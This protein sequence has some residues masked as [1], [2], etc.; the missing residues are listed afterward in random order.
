MIEGRERKKARKDEK[1]KEKKRKEKKRKE[2]KRK[3]KKR[4]EK[5]RKG[6]KRKEKERKGKKRKE[7]ERKGKERK[8]KKRKKQTFRSS[9]HLAVRAFN[10][11]LS[12]TFSFLKELFH[13][14]LFFSLNITELEAGTVAIATAFDGDRLLR[15]VGTG[16]ATSEFNVPP[17]V[18]WNVGFMPGPSEAGADALATGFDNDD[19]LLRFVR[20]ESATNAFNIPPPVPGNVGFAP[21]SRRE[22]KVPVTGSGML[23][24]FV[25]NSVHTILNDQWSLSKAVATVP[26]SDDPG[27]KPTFPGRII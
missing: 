11:A 23:N 4:K 20:T 14:V 2:K 27:V 7:K 15:I 1:R 13:Q 24:A 25:A 18:P 5:E 12:E 17:P 16:I 21:G 3:E 22:T 19:W 26:A 10:S 6:K 8:E 9:S